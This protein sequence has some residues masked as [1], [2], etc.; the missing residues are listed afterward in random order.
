VF[1]GLFD[2]RQTVT[3]YFAVLAIFVAGFLLI[4]R[5]IYSPFG[6]VLKAIRENEPRAISLGYKVDRHKLLVFTLSAALAGLAGSAKTAFFHLATLH[7]VEWTTSAQVVLI[8]LVGG[9]GTMLGPLVGAFVIVGMQNYLAE[10]GSLVTVV[11]GI[12]FVA[13][14]L[15]FRQGIVGG[16][17]RLLG[18]WRP[19]PDP[20][21]A[22]ETPPFRRTAP[23]AS[24]P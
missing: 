11:Q 2:L 16:A 5:T 17:L 14:V 13:C 18:R 7:D 24:P 10:Y 21:P 19:Q 1:L 12:V 22:H 6:Q 3:V 23:D 8:T 20:E 4:Y 9:L 15:A